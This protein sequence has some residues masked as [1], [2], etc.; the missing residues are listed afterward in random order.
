MNS[1]HPVKLGLIGAGIAAFLGSLF[2]DHYRG[3]VAPTASGFTDITAI[4]MQIAAFASV[5]MGAFADIKKTVPPQIWASV[6]RMIASKKL[7]VGEV[8]AIVLGKY[9]QV[10]YKAILEIFARLRAAFPTFKM[11]ADDGGDGKIDIYV[12][13][14][15]DE[16]TREILLCSTRYE[17]R[18]VEL[19]LSVGGNTVITMNVTESG[20][21]VIPPAPSLVR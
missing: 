5:L 18:P 12:P 19:N 6:E 20:Q 17:K 2:Y 21:V 15:D 16:I 7:D 4:V 10:D 3:P 8:I 1:N 9:G 14:T 11:D 13:A